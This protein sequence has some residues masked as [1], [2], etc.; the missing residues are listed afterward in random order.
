MMTHQTL[1]GRKRVASRTGAP[2]DAAEAKIHAEA[3]ECDEGND[4]ELMIAM[5]CHEE[6][7]LDP[8]RARSEIEAQGAR[9]IARAMERIRAMRATA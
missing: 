3:G 8:A 9:A 6:P 2:S 5:R 1:L 7:D 4:L